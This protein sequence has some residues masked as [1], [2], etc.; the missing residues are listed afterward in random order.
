MNNE[1]K[2]ISFMLLD[3]LLFV[4]LAT[5]SEFMGNLLLQTWHSSF[6]FSFSTA[7][8]L[9]AMVRWGTAG[10]VVGMLG[11]LPGMLFSGLPFF[12]GFLFYGI[13]N[14]LIGLPML[15]YGK[16]ERNRLAGHY[17]LLSLYILL[18]HI[19]LSLGKGIVIFL[20]TGEMTGA[21]DYFAATCFIL[22]MNLILCCVLKS[23]DGLICDMR[24]Y[25]AKTD[26]DTVH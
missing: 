1:S 7:L 17:G 22:V 14:L 3:L 20:L 5:L 26:S 2:V 16:R 9:I 18:S 25:F 4:I 23:R 12:S 15:L 13:A 24:Y 6:Y 21:V 8:C 19:C 11:G 10:A